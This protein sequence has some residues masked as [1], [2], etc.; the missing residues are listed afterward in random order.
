MEEAFK[1][2]QKRKLKLNYQ[3]MYGAALDDK[4]KYNNILKYKDF[5]HVRIILNLILS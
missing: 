5:D 2:Y 3:E 1:R 4:F